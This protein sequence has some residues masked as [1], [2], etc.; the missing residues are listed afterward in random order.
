MAISIL[1]EYIK[2]ITN[3]RRDEAHG[4]PALH[5]PLLLL[6]VIE[7]IEH[8]QIRDNKIF[9]KDL[10]ETF[11]KYCLGVKNK[12]LNIAMPFFHLKNSKDNAPFWHLHSNI[13][14][15][16][17][18]NSRRKVK[19]IGW[20]HKVVAYASL[21][22]PLFA[23]LID[24]TCQ[25][26]IRQAII[27]EYFSNLKQEIADLIEERQ[28]IRRQKIV[29]YSESLIENTKCPFSL[30]NPQKQIVSIQRKTAVRK[31]GFRQAIMQIYDHTC[32]VCGLRICIDGKSITDAAH[33]AP[34]HKFHN[35]DVRN[36]ISLCKS[37]HWAFDEGL[38]SLDSLDDTYKIIISPS[39]PQCESTEW[40]FTKLKGEKIAQLP[41]DKQQYPAQEALEWHREEI[42]RE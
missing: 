4:D 32:A 10:R 12:T 30:Y 38:I 33:I 27:S 37:H 21:D 15:E 17:E 40:L 39:I 31:A 34:F 1:Q 7:L 24:S 29:E 14:Y 41:D 20:L 23:L 36:G 42:F 22:A 28:N 25:E 5:Q 6:T 11:K 35:D 18:L 2:K 8:E 16:E 26:A 13:G 3:M 9:L 19:E